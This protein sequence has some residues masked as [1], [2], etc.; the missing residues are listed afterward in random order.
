MDNLMISFRKSIIGKQLKL[1]N[2]ESFDS[3]EIGQWIIVY[4]FLSWSVCQKTCLIYAKDF[5]SNMLN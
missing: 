4:N 3:I 5:S 1:K 2:S